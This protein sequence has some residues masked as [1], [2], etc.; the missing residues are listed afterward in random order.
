MIGSTRYEEKS[1]KRDV[2]QA[3][4]ERP[5][6]T[7]PLADYSVPELVSYLTTAYPNAPLEV[8]NQLVY[9]NEVGQILADQTRLILEARQL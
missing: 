5:N 1:M 4:V 9:N 7:K 3:R 2:F 6:E 8:L